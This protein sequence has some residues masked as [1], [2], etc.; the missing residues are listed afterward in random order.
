LGLTGPR[1]RKQLPAS[2]AAISR[3]A[4]ASAG[5]RR[6]MSGLLVD[7]PQPPPPRG[8]RAVWQVSLTI[9]AGSVE[10]VR[11]GVGRSCAAVNQLRESR[12][13]RGETA[14][15]RVE[16]AQDWRPKRDC[17]RNGENRKARSPC[18]L[19]SSGRTGGVNQLH[20]RKLEKTSGSPGATT[21][22]F[23]PVRRGTDAGN[24]LNSTGLSKDGSPPGG[25]G[26]PALETGPTAHHAPHVM[27]APW[28]SAPAAPGRW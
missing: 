5:S 9:Y 12:Q 23:A 28:L 6:G 22:C 8:Q 14:S 2:R 15:S 3:T 20:A 17:A 26:A 18:R 21:Y 13:R 24:V 25:S 10:L 27:A 1:R 16:E 7:H 11:F 4:S 19:G